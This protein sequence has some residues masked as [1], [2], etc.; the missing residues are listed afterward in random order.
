MS[1]K[2]ICRETM[3]EL[4][5]DFRASLQFGDGDFA[6]MCLMDIRR[7]FSERHKTEVTEHG[8]PVCLSSQA[9]G[10]KVSF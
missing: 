9:G 4:I 2:S 8:W 6:K 1:I 10:Q 5:W 7:L 3:N